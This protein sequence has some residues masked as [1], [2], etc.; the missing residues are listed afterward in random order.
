MSIKVKV[1]GITNALDAELALS[2]GASELGFVLAPSPRRVEPET[3]RSIVEAL[4]GSPRLGAFRAVG[5]FVNERGDTMRDI[6]SYSGLDLAQVHGDESPGDCESFGFPWYRALRL[7]SAAEAER[8]CGMPWRC[9]R[10]LVDASSGSAY[11]GT[12]LSIGTWATLAARAWTREGGKEFFVAGG[13][14]PGNAA[15]FVYSYSPDGLDVSSGVEESPGRKSRDKLK[16]LFDEIRA[17]E[18]EASCAAR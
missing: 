10:L 7:G 18:K 4:R 13:I 9:G 6:M 14:K 1:C 15:S 12:G 2:L 11:G 17:A 3:V 5:V 16:A 8:L